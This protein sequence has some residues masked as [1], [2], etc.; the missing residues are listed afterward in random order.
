MIEVIYPQTT[1]KHA[2]Y[3]YLLYGF[4][5]LEKQ[6]K[7]KL[8]ISPI[9]IKTSPA[10]IPIQINDYTVYYDYSDFIPLTLEINNAPYFKIQY[11]Q[12]HFKKK[13]VFSIG[14]V[15]TSL[16]YLQNL[17]T[18]RKIKDKNNYELDVIGLFRATNYK[19]RCKAVELIKKENFNSLVGVSGYRNRPPVPSDLKG[20]R[21]D[22]YEHLQKQCQS[23][24]CLSLPG[25]GKG[26]SFWSWRVS[27]ILGI[28]GCMIT[29]KPTCYLPGN[30]KNCWIEVKDDLSNFIGQVSYY[31]GHDKEREE[32]AL[33][34][35]KYF[36]NYLRSDK[37]CNYIIEKTLDYYNV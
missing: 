35:R 33:N 12:E 4:Q 22:Y 18:L 24:L 10:I 3:N 2:W 36:D 20:L 27:E 6:K 21:I 9:K 16:K 7:I 29:T 28:G 17:N 1:K 5:D 32:I 25:V 30:P 31:L 13:N 37:M 23:K 15:V 34:G 26:T 14:Q 8:T 11:H 19:L